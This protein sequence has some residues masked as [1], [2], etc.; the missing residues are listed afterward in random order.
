MKEISKINIII[1]TYNAKNLLKKCVSSIRR[2]THSPYLITVVDNGSSDGTFSFLKKQ[3]DVNIIR[4]RRN[5]GFSRAMNQGIKNTHN[6]LIVCLDDDVTVTENWLDSLESYIENSNVGIVGCKIIFPDGKIHA[7]EYSIKPRMV[8]GKGELDFGQ[9]EYVREVDALIGPCWLMKREVIKKIGYFDERFYPCQHE[10][11]DFCIRARLAGYKIIYNGK[12]KIVHHNIYRDNGQSEK[13]WKKFL[14]KWKRLRYPFKD[15]HAASKHNARGYDLFFSGE[16]NKALAEFKK[17]ENINR[18]FSMP[19]Y[20]SLS[21]FVLGKHGDAVKT[22]RKLLHISPDDYFSRYL[23]G[24]LF[25]ESGR[26]KEAIN[27]YRKVLKINPYAS[28][29]HY[30]IGMLYERVGKIKDARL[31]YKKAL[32][33]MCSYEKRQVNK[34]EGVEE[35]TI[36]IL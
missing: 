20:M 1:V 7:A 27:E 13:N 25:L 18:E 30:K 32:N 15:S 6:R 17:A 10:D 4:N 35:H 29:V 14:R 24:F 16:A 21:Q 26:N 19:Y 28:D 8:V 22:L 34:M 33:C 3:G 5:L 23:L 9:K 12:G 31:E 11:L 36:A 2:F